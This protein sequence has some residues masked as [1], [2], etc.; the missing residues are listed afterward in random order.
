KLVDDELYQ[1]YK[2]ISGDIQSGGKKLVFVSDKLP[3]LSHYQINN[4]KIICES[5]PNKEVCS[6]HPHCRW[7]YSTCTFISTADNLIKMINKM[8]DELVSNDL[9]A[10]EI[11]RIGNYFV[12]DIGDYNKFTERKGQT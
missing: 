8:A 9:K 5:N 10:F 4:D 7:V 3:D 1:K 12:S 2:K 11:L 6:I